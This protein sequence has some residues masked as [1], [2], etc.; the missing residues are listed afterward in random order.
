[1]AR[2]EAPSAATPWEASSSNA[3][4]ERTACYLLSEKGLPARHE[5]L[6]VTQ[7]LEGTRAGMLPGS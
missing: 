5:P 2:L 6:K 7:S 4:V 1:M 3:D